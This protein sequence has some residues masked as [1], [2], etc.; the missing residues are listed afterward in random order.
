MPS[1]WYALRVRSR[2][3]SLVSM[4]LRGK[5][6][7]VFYPTYTTVHR[8]SDRTKTL[9]YPLFPSYVFC[10]F[11]VEKRL[12][13]LITPGVLAVAAAGRVPTAVEDAEIEALRLVVESGAPY[14]PHLYVAV[15]ERVRI[16]EGPLCGL[17]GLVIQ[18][19]SNFRLVLSVDLLMR[20]VAVE[21]DA[22]SVENARESTRLAV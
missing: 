9:Q 4:Q 2:F 17:T 13:I 16:K 7:E 21:I 8:W 10:S 18:T 3:E 11:D 20:S 12:P 5:G 6:Y 19:K 22:S 14:Q 15:G 1:N